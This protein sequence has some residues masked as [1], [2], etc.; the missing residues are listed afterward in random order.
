MSSPDRKRK[1]RTLDLGEL[2]L[3]DIQ[4]VLTQLRDMLL[5]SN[6]QQR[7]VKAILWLLATFGLTHK[8]LKV[9][10]EELPSFSAAEWD[11]VCCVFELDASLGHEQ[12][13]RFTVP[14]L[15][16]PPSVHHSILKYAVKSLDV[17][18]DPTK[19]ENEAAHVR[20][21]EAVRTSLLFLAKA[22]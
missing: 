7:V 15:I 14:D 5:A 12:L 11:S 18:R 17:Y 2:E 19:H 8:Q 4:D 9:D 21:L 1:R 13:D 6:D 3:E 22:Q 16:L 10:A 20:V